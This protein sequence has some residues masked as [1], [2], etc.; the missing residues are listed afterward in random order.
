MAR[1]SRDEMLMRMAIAAALRST[2]SRAHVGVVIAREGRVLSTGY[3]GA[4]AGMD[5][6]NHTHD[7][8]SGCQ[9]A[10]HAEANAIAYAARYGMKIGGSELFTTLSPCVSCSQLIVNAGIERVVYLNPYRVPSGLELLEGAG[11]LLR[12]F[13][14]D[15]MEA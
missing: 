12:H 11:V 1:I 10:V 15:M 5:H 3:N 2:C 9:V 8:E 14:D 4:P 13:R 7:L 6:C